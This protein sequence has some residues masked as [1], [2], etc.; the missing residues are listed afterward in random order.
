[1]SSYFFFFSGWINAASIASNGNHGVSIMFFI[2]AGL[3]TLL[4]IIYLYLLRRVLFLCFLFIHTGLITSNP[5]KIHTFECFSLI[6]LNLLLIVCFGCPFF[7]NLLLFMK[8]K[9]PISQFFFFCYSE[10]LTAF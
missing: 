8:K 2:T 6:Y 9:K 4:F 7:S 5:L 1:M 3:F 10:N